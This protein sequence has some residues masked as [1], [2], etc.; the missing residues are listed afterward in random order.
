[1]SNIDILSNGIQKLW[2]NFKDGF[3]AIQKGDTGALKKMD[4]E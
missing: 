3:H 1:M 4:F 2:H